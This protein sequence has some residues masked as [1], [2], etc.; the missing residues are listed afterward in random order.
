MGSFK[1]NWYLERK[2]GPFG[3]QKMSKFPMGTRVLKWGLNVG[4]VSMFPLFP[5]GIYQDNSMDTMECQ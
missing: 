1:E 2:W 5:Y 4:T 3:D